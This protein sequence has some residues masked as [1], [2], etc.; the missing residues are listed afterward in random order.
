MEKRGKDQSHIWAD[1]IHDCTHQWV[2][3]TVGVQARYSILML[4]SFQQKQVFRAR[5]GHEEN[6]P[7]LFPPAIKKLGKILG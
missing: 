6:N 5:N 7:R 4:D 2:G 3:V 1:V